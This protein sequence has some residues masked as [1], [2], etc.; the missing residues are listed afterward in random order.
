MENYGLSDYDAGILIKDINTAN[1]FEKCIDLGIDA[2]ITANW[3]TGN[4]LGYTYKFCWTTI[5]K[6][7]RLM[8]HFNLER[9]FFHFYQTW[10]IIKTQ[11]NVGRDSCDRC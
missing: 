7:Y 5:F 3:I 4:I 6:E 10:H 1:Y 9:R 2:K 11:Y 8:N